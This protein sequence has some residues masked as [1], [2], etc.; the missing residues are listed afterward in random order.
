[1]LVRE[2]V[3]HK[4]QK[5]LSRENKVMFYFLFCNLD[6]FAIYFSMYICRGVQLTVVFIFNF[7]TEPDAKLYTCS[8]YLLSVSYSSLL[9]QL[10]FLSYA[11]VMIAQLQLSCRLKGAARKAETC[12]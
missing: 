6:W 5:S 2:N 4:L 10:S 9:R 1:M 12:V 3:R 11:H 8:E 7:S